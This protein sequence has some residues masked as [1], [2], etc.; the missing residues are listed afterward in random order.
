M[1]ERLTIIVA[2]TC[3]VV[4]SGCAIQQTNGNSSTSVNTNFPVNTNAT[5]VVNSNTNTVINATPVVKEF[6]SPLD[7]PAERITKKPFGIYITP[8]ASPVQP[9]RF[10]G[11]HTGVDFEILAGEEDSDV[12]VTAGCSGTVRDKQRVSGYGGV[13]VQD[14]VL[15]GENVTVLYGHLNLDSITISVGDTL[16]QGDLIGNLGTG[17]STQTDNERKHLHVSVHKGT[18]V[19]YKGY[20]SLESALED[21]IDPQE[22]F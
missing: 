16:H 17:Y 2:L 1:R 22:Y 5:P 3:C 18:G 10:S 12:A 15:A 9:E 20:V 6:I 11:F 14:C 7:K 4:L 21:W 8:T 19:N 13:L